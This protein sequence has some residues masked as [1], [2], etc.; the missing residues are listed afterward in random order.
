MNVSGSDPKSSEDFLEVLFTCTLHQHVSEPTRFKHG[1]SPSLFDLVITN[2]EGM[3]SDFDHLSLQFT[4]NLATPN[5]N[6]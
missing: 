4:F 3:I 1:V 2:E 5:D 6:L